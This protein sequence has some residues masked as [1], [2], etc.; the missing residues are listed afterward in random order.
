MTMTSHITRY[1]KMPIPPVEEQT[2]WFDAGAIR[3]GVEYRLLND[4]IAAASDVQEASG[5]DSGDALGFDDCGVSLHVCGSGGGEYLEYG[6]GKRLYR[7]H[8]MSRHI[9]GPLP[10]FR[11]FVEGDDSWRTDYRWEDVT[12]ELRLE[13]EPRFR[14]TWLVVLLLI[15]LLATLA[16]VL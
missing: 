8:A 9:R 15:G 7:A 4:A 6:E 11:S 3:I 12:H 10:A 2:E 5:A 16:A 14:L 13:D 1:D